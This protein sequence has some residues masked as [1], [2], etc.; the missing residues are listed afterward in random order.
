MI[1]PRLQHVSFVVPRGSQE[2][3]RAF[4]GGVL[5]LEEKQPPQ[6][7]AHRQLVWFAAGE[8]EMELHFMPSDEPPNENG[9]HFCLEVDVLDEYRQRLQNAGIAILEAE[10]IPG[11]PRFFCHDPFGNLIELTTLVAEYQTQQ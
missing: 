5:G 4:Y 9:Q 1:R 7:L 11:R 6:S 8:G 3:V 2:A 10:P